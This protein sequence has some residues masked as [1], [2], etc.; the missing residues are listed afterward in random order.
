VSCENRHIDDAVLYKTFVNAFNIMVENKD[1]FLEKWH[2]VG[3][4][5]VL[6]KYRGGEFIKIITKAAFIGEFDIDIYFKIIEKMIVL[7]GNK[8][9]VFLLD[10]TEIEC[11]I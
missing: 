1:Y 8:I 4:E 2:Q 5:N 11:G 6:Q 10:G 3:N 7:E 9:I